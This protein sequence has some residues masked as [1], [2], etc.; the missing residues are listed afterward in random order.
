MSTASNANEHKALTGFVEVRGRP[1]KVGVNERG[2]YV[3]TGEGWAL[4]PWHRIEAIATLDPD[5]SD[6]GG[7]DLNATLAAR[8][9][10]ASSGQTA[11]P[12]AAPSGVCSGASEAEAVAPGTGAESPR[13]RRQKC[14]ACDTLWNGPR[15]TVCAECI[16]KGVK[17]AAVPG[18]KLGTLSEALGAPPPATE[19]A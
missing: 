6:P 11:F 15:N 9:G 13:K 19:P 12:F 14:P 4:L 10:G 16:A 3:L 2:V 8:Q 18:A 1:M 7:A 17:P 5:A